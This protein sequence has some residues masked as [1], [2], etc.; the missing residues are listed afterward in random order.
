MAK[1]HIKRK[2]INIAFINFFPY[3]LSKPWLR[4]LF[5]LQSHFDINATP[6]E[7]SNMFTTKS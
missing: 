3:S 4:D 2:V 6:N 5:M 1:Y 7:I